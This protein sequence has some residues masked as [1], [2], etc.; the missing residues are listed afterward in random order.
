MF[1]QNGCWRLRSAAVWGYRSPAPTVAQHVSVC[2]LYVTICL[3][4]PLPVYVSLWIHVCTSECIYICISVYEWLCVCIC[5]PLCIFLRIY[6][7]LCI[8]MC[9]CLSGGNHVPESVGVHSCVC[10]Y[11]HAYM[12]FCACCPY[13]KISRLEPCIS[14]RNPDQRLFAIHCSLLAARIFQV[15]LW[16]LGV[17]LPPSHGVLTY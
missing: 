17:D 16:G 14:L 13:E 11:M 3:C 9:A 8:F 6:V 5:V 2:S 1:A 12:L 10:K 15:S 4:I 7:Y